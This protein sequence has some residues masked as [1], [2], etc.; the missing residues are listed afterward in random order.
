[1]K[2]R[3]FLLTFLCT[4]LNCFADG[5]FIYYRYSDNIE[6]EFET[7]ENGTCQLYYVSCDSQNGDLLSIKVPSSITEHGFQYTVV[8]IGNRAFW[9]DVYE[10]IELPETIETIGMGAFADLT[11]LKSVNIP[12]SVTEIQSTAFY[13]TGLESVVIPNNVKTLSLWSFSWCTSLTDIQLPAGLEVIEDHALYNTPS[14]KAITLPNKLKFIG[15]YAFGFSGIESITIPN[16]VET[17]NSHAFQ[18]C[19]G[20]KKLYI[21]YSVKEMGDNIVLRCSLDELSVSYNNEYFTMHNNMLFSKDLSTLYVASLKEDKSEN[22]TVADCS[23]IRTS[24]YSWYTNVH[25]LSIP[26]SVTDLALFPCSR[27]H[28]ETIEVDNNNPA[29]CSYNGCLYSKDKSEI[30]IVPVYKNVSNFTFVPETVSIAEEAFWGN[31]Y[32]M[33]ISIPTQIKSIGGAAFGSCPDLTSVAI[34][35]SSEAISMVAYP[36]ADSPVT[37]FLLLRPCE[38]DE[39]FHTMG[40]SLSDLTFGKSYSY[41]NHFILRIVPNLEHLTLHSLNPPIF[42]EEYPVDDDQYS[43]ILLTVPEESKTL[44][45]HAEY[46]RNFINVQYSGI[47]NVFADNDDRHNVYDLKGHLILSNVTKDEALSNLPNGLYIIGNSKVIINK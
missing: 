27:D 33:N 2:I 16:S 1:M 34:E 9:N 41:F 22:L 18:M 38:N 13:N 5:E 11:N 21:P 37:T 32:L 29:Y 23:V 25:K 8:K 4:V 19:E 7:L 3:F 35:E 10:S 26:A 28:L 31:K 46:W 42:A 43:K 15:A 45:A 30:K 17:I 40:S 12:S 39:I 20:L 47:D 36:F 24:A 44:Y 14:L 6:M